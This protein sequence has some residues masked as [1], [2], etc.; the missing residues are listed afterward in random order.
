MDFTNL[1]YLKNGNERQQKAYAALMDNRIMEIL[2]PFDPILVGTIPIGIDVAGSDLDI[3]CQWKKVPVFLQHIRKSFSERSNFQMVVEKWGRSYVVIANFTEGGIPIEIFAQ[4]RPA[5]LQ[6]GYRHMV[7]EHQILEKMGSLFRERII[8]LK[9]QGVKTEPA[10]AQVL[11]LRGD[12]YKA[13]LK[14]DLESL[15]P[16]SIFR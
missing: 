5:H 10:F 11:G 8:E 12:P 13:L 3:I 14:V 7:I 1:N 9:Q 15:H 6:N 2:A 16:L 4:S